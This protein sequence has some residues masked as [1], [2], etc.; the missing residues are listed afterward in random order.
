VVGVLVGILR[1]S[2]SDDHL[3]NNVVRFGYIIDMKIKIYIIFIL[4]NLI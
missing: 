4:L 2:Q 1:S 3:K